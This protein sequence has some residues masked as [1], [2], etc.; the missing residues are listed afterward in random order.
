MNA[1]VLGLGLSC[2]VFACGSI[3][4]IDPPP[5][6]ESGDPPPSSTPGTPPGATNPKTP[7]DPSCKTARAEDEARDG[8]PALAPADVK[9][10]VFTDYD[11]VG[12]V[13]KIV[14]TFDSGLRVLTEA[15][16]RLDEPPR[17]TEHDQV[18][19]IPPRHLTVTNEYDSAGRLVHTWT[20]D[21]ANG[22]IDEE[23]WWA[24]DATGNEITRGSKWGT[25]THVTTRTFM[26]GTKHLMTEQTDVTGSPSTSVTWTRK[27]DGSPLTHSITRGAVVESSSTWT[28]DR[29]G[30]ATQVEQQPIRRRTVIT[31]AAGRVI[32]TRED[33]PKD[34]VDDYFH[35]TKYNA[36]GDVLEDHRFGKN[37][38][39]YGDLVNQYDAGGRLV[40]QWKQWGFGQVNGPTTDVEKRVYDACGQLVSIKRTQNG[41]AHSEVART[42]DANGFL[43]SEESHFFKPKK[44]S[45]KALRTFDAQGRLTK[46]ESHSLSGASFTLDMTE[47]RSYDAAGHLVSIVRTYK[48]QPTQTETFKLDTMGRL[49]LHEKT[50]WNAQSIVKE[51]MSYAC[52]P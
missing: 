14:R 16:D 6:E 30:G 48:N 22:S 2:F 7:G 21:D 36:N 17:Q 41:Q 38:E 8:V 39:K 45:T 34:G 33:Q 31:D 44:T 26:S 46:L 1:R 24:F 51:E 18:F 25:S 10:C 35:Q 28:Y 37:G 12:P 13:L 9:P 5:S 52:Q 3:A 19:V 40:E 32:E 42:Y 11:G 43:A 23:R 50:P 29:N 47:T 49:V 27:S 4:S 15:T 20:D